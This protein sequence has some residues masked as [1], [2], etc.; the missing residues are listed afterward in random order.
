MNSSDIDRQ[1]RLKAAGERRQREIEK[2]SRTDKE[3]FE[4][5]F[6]VRLKNLRKKKQYSIG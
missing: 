3:R 1:N 4:N 2:N 5:A 6:L